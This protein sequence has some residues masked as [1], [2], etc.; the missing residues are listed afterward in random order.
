MKIRATLTISTLG[1]AFATMAAAVTSEPDTVSTTAASAAQATAP[2]DAAAYALSSMDDDGLAP[3]EDLP[4]DELNTSTPLGDIDTADWHKAAEEY[5]Q[6][7]IEDSES[8]SP[9]DEQAAVTTPRTRSEAGAGLPYA[10]TGAPAHRPAT[11][12]AVQAALNAQLR[13][14]LTVDGIMGPRTVAALKTYQLRQGLPANGHVG[15]ETLAKLGVVN[16]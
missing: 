5:L 11:V 4:D 15:P 9:K 2:E 12:A 14:G 1:L 13:A 16:R 3:G 10:L 7:T 6:R 8:P